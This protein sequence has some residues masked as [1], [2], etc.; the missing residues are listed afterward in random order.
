VSAEIVGPTLF[1]FFFL[2]STVWVAAIV[3]TARDADIVPVICRVRHD[4]DAAT[5]CCT[6]LVVG[7]SSSLPTDESEMYSSTHCCGG[8]TMS[9]A[10]RTLK[11]RS[12]SLC[13]G[14]GH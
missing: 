12:S 2:A 13:N 14:A 5:F 6:L 8:T 7:A 11:L 10:A 3:A 4:A 9:S 1:L